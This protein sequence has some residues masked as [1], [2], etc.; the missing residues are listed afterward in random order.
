V[1]LLTR[2]RDLPRRYLLADGGFD[3]A[4]LARDMGIETDAQ[5][6]S[7]LLTLYRLDLTVADR[8]NRRLLYFL[9]G[10][11][12]KGILPPFEAPPAEETAWRAA[13]AHC[14]GCPGSELVETIPGVPFPR[15]G[16][17]DRIE[18]WES[19]LKYRENLRSAPP[20][21]APPAEHVAG[22]AEVASDIEAFEASVDRLIAEARR[23]S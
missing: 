4:L 9:I 13:D 10:R 16:N 22:H 1:D 19:C 21:A 2:M 5:W 12:L 14:E 17:P 18:R 23:P 8:V 3:F 15:C 20:A 6:G 7:L 11:E